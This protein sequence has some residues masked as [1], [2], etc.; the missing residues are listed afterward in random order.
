MWPLPSALSTDYE[1]KQETN[2]HLLSCPSTSPAIPDSGNFCNQSWLIP[3]FG[4]R[5]RSGV[6]IAGVDAQPRLSALL[7]TRQYFIVFCCVNC[8]GR[9]ANWF[10]LTPPVHG[11]PGASWRNLGPRDRKKRPCSRFRS[12]SGSLEPRRFPSCQSREKRRMRSY[13]NWQ[14]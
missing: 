14:V 11:L 9:N 5:P 13:T 8:Q 3:Q 1:G 2:H 7:S 4:G 6:K 10:V 12:C